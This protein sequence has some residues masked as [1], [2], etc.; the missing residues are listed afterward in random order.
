MFKLFLS[1][2]ALLI[3][4]SMTTLARMTKLALSP[5]NQDTMD[6]E[7]WKLPTYLAANSHDSKMLENSK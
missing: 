2:F 7:E 3:S 6:R 1:L 5:F 4:L